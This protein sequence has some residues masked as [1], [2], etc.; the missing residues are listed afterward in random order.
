MKNR[1][2]DAIVKQVPLHP[3]PFWCENV[4]KIYST[5]V[6]GNNHLSANWTPVDF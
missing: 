3:S 4:G 5:L 2:N 1:G 6:F